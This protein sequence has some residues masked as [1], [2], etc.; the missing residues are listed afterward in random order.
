MLTVEDIAVVDAHQLRA[1][2]SNGVEGV[3]D[4]SPYMSKGIFTQLRNPGYFAQV[5]INFCGICWPNGQD[6][7]AD[8]IAYDLNHP[9]PINS[10]ATPE[11]EQTAIVTDEK[12]QKN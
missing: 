2:L 7:S 3:F 12:V 4:V 6:F 5:R 9:Q 11:D 8:T 10:A 1:K